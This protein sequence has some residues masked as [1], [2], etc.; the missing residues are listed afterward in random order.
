MRTLKSEYI[1]LSANQR[2]LRSDLPIIALTGGIASG[3]STVSS[4]LERQGIQVVCA[5]KVIKDIYKHDST[6]ELITELAPE[7][8]KQSNIDFSKLRESFFSD[9]ALKSKIE[10]YLFNLYPDFLQKSFDAIQNQNFVIYDVPL[11]FEK[12]LNKSVDQSIC[13]YTMKSNQIERIQKRDGSTLKVAQAI[14]N[15]QMSLEK[16][17]ELS[18]FVINNTEDINS[19]ILQTDKLIN[20]LFSIE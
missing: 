8:V 16:K 20:L 12:K 17:R 13:V 9:V 11:L 5:D 1:K 10:N 3:K 6:I 18:Q 14:I 19:V 15:A 2:I 4:H 7:C